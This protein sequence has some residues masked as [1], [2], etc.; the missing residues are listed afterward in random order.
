[1]DV[2]E[3]GAA[4][5]VGG[6]E[7]RASSSSTI[8]RLL[9]A[10]EYRGD[11]HPLRILGSS[12]VFLGLCAFCSPAR[13]TFSIVAAEASTGTLGSVG[14]SCVPYEVIRILA[15]AQGKGLLVAQANFDDNAL[16]QG[17]SMLAAGELPASVLATITDATKFPPAPKMQYGIVDIAGKT[18][19]Y[20]GPE[21]FA[22]AG[23]KAGEI[24]GI[25][26]TVQG[27]ILTGPTVLEQMAA[28]MAE[29]CDL[30]ERIMRGLEG[31]GFQGGGDSRCTDGGISAA[32]AYI[33][34]EEK[35]QTILR[36]SLPD[37]RPN[38]PI[39]QLR[40]QFDAWRMSH[41]CPTT[42]PID[43]GSTTGGNPEMTP[44]CSMSRT[45]STETLGYWILAVIAT[46]GIRRRPRQTA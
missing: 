42:E 10:I 8:D 25:A 6:A 27:N 14:A 26:Y 44:G 15:V 9:K 45:Q 37:T 31:A 43:A 3:S 18:A 11:M 28:A 34:V 5:G 30:P 22:Y 24:N 39:A 32:S 40:T 12:A 17:Q 46:L 23:D 35:G 13:A 2:E 21:A 16:A 29:G 1:L 20:T 4:V 7:K 19:S 33:L 38:D 36:I 41:P